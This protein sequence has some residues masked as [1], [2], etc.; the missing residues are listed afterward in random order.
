MGEYERFKLIDYV[1]KYVIA[2]D[3]SSGKTTITYFLQHNKFL[4]VHDTTIG[5]DFSS[6]TLDMKNGKVIK[7]QLWDTAGQEQYSS[8]IKSYFRDP[9]GCIIVLDITNPKKTLL[10]QLKKWEKRV[11]ESSDNQQYMKI[12][13]LINKIDKE[14]AK[15]KQGEINET[16]EYC[17]RKKYLVYETSCKRSFNV[18]ESI[19]DFTYSIYDSISD[20]IDDTK[21]KG[22]K[23]RE[24][25]DKYYNIDLSDTR[26]DKGR[27]SY[28]CD[29]CSIC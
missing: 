28:Y 4:D 9:I 19:Y 27:D 24:I 13:I 21:I 23:N 12:L 18:Y 22:V 2:G 5:V 10:N 15:F 3:T 1:F 11:L 6:K 17:E 25:L 20:K 8:I 16:I 26:E 14:D 7:I 29:S